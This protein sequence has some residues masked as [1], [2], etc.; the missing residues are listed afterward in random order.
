MT[1][2]Q[3]IS[4]K[5]ESKIHNPDLRS[6]HKDIIPISLIHKINAFPIALQFQNHKSQG[7]E[8]SLGT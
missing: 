3:T 2:I 6:N 7:S 1:Y 5:S 4:V 8:S